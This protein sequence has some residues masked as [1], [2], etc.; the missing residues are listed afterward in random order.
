MRL[1]VYQDGPFRV[2]SGDGAAPRIVAD[3][4][5]APFFR[6]VSQVAAGFDEYVVFARVVGRADDPDAR[7]LLPAEARLVE[8][9]D[10]GGLRRLPN[11]ARAAF[12]TLAAFWRG[13]D[14]VDA[15]WTFGPQPF[16]LVLVFLALI[17]RKRVV[18]GVRQ[19]TPAY[20]RARI[21]GR[22]WKP[23]LAAIDLMDGVHRRLA[24]RVPATI[25]GP[26]NAA[27]Y[28]A[29]TGRVLAM[30]PSLVPA[31]AV[32]EEPPPRD[33][34][35]PI[36]LLTVGRVD[37]EKNPPLV[38]QLLAEL[39]RLRPGRYRLRWVGT[40]PLMDDV[41]RRASELGVGDRL[42]LVGFVPFGPEL[43]D[44]YRGAHAFVH[45]SLTEG[46]PQV[47]VEALASGTPIVATDVGDVRT[48]VADGEAALLVP[49]SD[50][51]ALVE[52]LLRLSDDVELRERLVRRGL[53][54]ARDGTLEAEAERVARF[55]RDPGAA[56]VSERR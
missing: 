32:V 24:N 7:L 33:W 49:P 40:G 6:F 26:A 11:V 48:A 47:L 17:R 45:I 54:L 18:L 15:V 19:D 35:R 56:S 38:A 27:R 43:L 25:V 4:A 28:G 10:Y 31:A 51:E 20:F 16:E 52:A 44:L 3:P 8:L 29:P 5:D 2:T 23:V 1:G 37:A 50:L 53:E 46:V 21:R 55:I 42:E 36:E 22:S 13:L 41:S 12:R 14:R 30:A 39:E 9:P 34:S